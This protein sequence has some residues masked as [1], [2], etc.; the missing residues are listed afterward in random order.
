MSEPYIIQDITDWP[1]IAWEQTIIMT[2]VAKD[3]ARKLIELNGESLLKR[4]FRY[5]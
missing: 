4:S 5:A 2:Q 1:Q 3:F